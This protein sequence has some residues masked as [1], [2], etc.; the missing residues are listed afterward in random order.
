[1]Q[2][3]E[4]TQGTAFHYT[5]LISVPSAV[6]TMRKLINCL[7]LHAEE[8]ILIHCSLGKDRTGVIIA[9]LLAL[10]GVA[11]DLIA[12]DYAR[13]APELLKMLPQCMKFARENFPSQESRSL[14]GTVQQMIT[15]N[16]QTMIVFLQNV[17]QEFG[18]AW[19]YFHEYCK[20][21]GSDLK[22]VRVRLIK[23]FLTG[24]N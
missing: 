23:P 11:D 17:R 19:G 1:M 10:A 20:I 9:L 3:A 4:H 2:E 12:D 13:S 16:R 22:A 8:A 21:D 6:L 5:K 7:Q 14:E 18:G 24:Q 15:A